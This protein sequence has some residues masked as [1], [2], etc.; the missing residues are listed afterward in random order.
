MG[1][2][3]R[4]FGVFRRKL[5]LCGG[6]SASSRSVRR[7]NRRRQ[8]S[9]TKSTPVAKLIGSSTGAIGNLADAAA[10]LN[11]LLSRDG[12]SVPP[13]KPAP[14]RRSRRAATPSKKHERSP[15]DG[16]TQRTAQGGALQARGQASKRSKAKHKG[17]AKEG[18]SGCLQGRGPLLSPGADIARMPLLVESHTPVREGL[19]QTME[20]QVSPLISYESPRPGGEAAGD[21][22]EAAGDIGEGAGQR[23]LCGCGKSKG[24]C[25]HRGG[26]GGATA[27]WSG[28]DKLELIRLLATH[29]VDG[30]AGNKAQLA[31][32]WLKVCTG[33]GNHYTQ[34][35][36]K[37]AYGR[38]SAQFTKQKS[39][40]ATRKPRN[41]PSRSG[42]GREESSSEDEDGSSDDG[43]TGERPEWMVAFGKGLGNLPK[44]GGNKNGLGLVVSDTLA[45][46][47]VSNMQHQPLFNS[48]R[49]QVQGENITTDRPKCVIGSPGGIK[50]LKS[51]QLKSE[52]ERL[53]LEVPTKPWGS[54]TGGRIGRSV[55]K[56]A[57][58]A[59]L[60]DYMTSQ[61]VQEGSAGKKGRGGS[62]GADARSMVSRKY[63][64]DVGES[65]TDARPSHTDMSQS[66]DDLES[67]KTMTELE[68]ATVALRAA[69]KQKNGAT[70]NVSSGQQHQG[71][72]SASE[73]K[74]ASFNL[75][76]SEGTTGKKGAFLA[77]LVEGQNRMLSTIM[78][79][80][81]GTP[82]GSNGGSN[83]G[84]LR[85]NS[86]EDCSSSSSS[87]GG[88]ENG[89]TGNT[90][91][92]PRS[93]TESEVLYAMEVL[94]TLDQ[95]SDGQRGDLEDILEGDNENKRTSLLAKLGM[96]S[97]PRFSTGVAF[98]TTHL[99]RYF[100]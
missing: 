10:S 77:Q 11:L 93:P 3:K 35:E 54:T 55:D 23:N 14:T 44:H 42:Q 97:S 62:T 72:A 9:T 65:G 47:G 41:P 75:S 1:R 70:T 81:S 67:L 38:M 71:A 20:A 43:S 74:A 64:Y 24:S 63:D 76:Q 17:N 32:R 58:Q 86:S 100:T 2:S 56:K 57:C 52:L 33:M 12:S 80:L 49:P 39:M 5:D 66:D 69:S 8:S 50:T 26:K 36:V 79:S 19:L 31:A 59:A 25:S 96:A 7:I 94:D 40:N 18:P 21:M 37:A 34:K 84:S 73:S 28:T 13:T 16:D 98:A 61:S 88:H 29:K 15:S 90:W 30:I 83:S 82:Q 60:L 89:P 95:L 99:T 51:A 22:G 27:S 48:P 78:G 4:A 68:E 92:R 53:G 46:G 6:M 45:E 85:G 87:T 91:M